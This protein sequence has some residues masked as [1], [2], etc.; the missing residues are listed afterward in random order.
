MWLWAA[1]GCGPGGG[2]IGDPACGAGRLCVQAGVPGLG[3]T[4]G[5]DWPARET[6]LYQPQDVTPVAGGFYVADTNNHVVRW[7]DD[8]GEGGVVAGSGFPDFGDGGPAR[9]EELHGPVMWVADPT[10]ADTGWIAVPAH[11]RI[12]RWTGDVIDYPYGLGAAGFSGDGGPASEG[13]FDRPAALAFDEEGALY[14]ADRM[15]QVVRRIDPD[16]TLSTVAGVPGEPGYAGDGGPADEAL[17]RAPWPTAQAAANRIAVA[18]GRLWIA[19][20]GNGAIRVVDLDTGLIDTLADGLTEP[21][22]VVVAP[23]GA[24]FVSD[25]GAGCVRRIAPDGASAPVVGRCGAPGPVVDGAPLSRARLGRPTGLA[26]GP[27]GA[28]W[29][30]DEQHHVVVRVGP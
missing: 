10:G 15:N 5:D 3:G 23:D 1:L 9:L 22:D 8:D 18:G 20:T 11:H 17:L 30:T 29:I 25:T 19:D 28:L 13:G 16:G 2:P 6:W 27:D 24:V 12:A 4:H 7:F 21:H 26:L 14:V